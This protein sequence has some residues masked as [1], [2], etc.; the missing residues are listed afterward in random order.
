MRNFETTL[1][2]LD[3]FSPEQGTTIISPPEKGKG[4]WSGG[5]YTMISKEGE[6]YLYYRVRRPRSAPY[7]EN[8]GYR[9]FIARSVDGISFKTIWS[10]D[11]KAFGARST[12]KG[13]LVQ[14]SDGKWLLY[15]SYDSEE[16]ERWQIDVM[17]AERP[18]SFDPAKR[19]IFLT[20]SDVGA[21]DVKDPHVFLYEGSYAIFANDTFEVGPREETL[22][23]LTEDGVNVS[24]IQKKILA[25]STN[26]DAWD[27]YSARLTGILPVT[28]GFLMFYDGQC[29]GGEVC[30]EN[31]GI[32]FSK[33]L[34]GPFRRI[35]NG[36]PFRMKVRY[37]Q[38]VWLQDSLILYY[39]FTQPCGGH[40]L[41]M[42]RLDD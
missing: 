8:R 41:R 28:D 37:V 6:V 38:G 42:A 9:C 24:E 25:P 16:T 2:L 36:K 5:S 26:R 12:E 35:S 29:F 30:E 21:H 15:V 34:L 7:G 20:C 27:G 17:E 33:N 11:K 39:E 13:C 31:C 23:A 1:G 4:F 18:G 40:A 10:A 14:R 32:C 19:R 3:S 22:V